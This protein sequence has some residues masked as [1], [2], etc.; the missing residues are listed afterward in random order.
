L[1]GDDNG[2]IKEFRIVTCLGLCDKG[3]C[4]I[5]NWLVIQ[6]LVTSLMVKRERSDTIVIAWTT[7][8]TLLHL[9]G[10]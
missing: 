1:N 8:I 4:F 3:D 10:A 9:S 7:L 6:C 2:V 5:E